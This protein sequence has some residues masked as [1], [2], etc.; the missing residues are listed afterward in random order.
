M[1]LVESSKS[2]TTESTKDIKQDIVNDSVVSLPVVEILKSAGV[3]ARQAATYACLSETIVQACIA[4]S[5]EPG[6]RNRVGYLISAL[7]KQLEAH[8]PASQILSFSEST[9]APPPSPLP[10]DLSPS[11]SPQAERGTEQ[12]SSLGD[13][14][15]QLEAE[16][17]AKV[18]EP[19]PVNERLLV[20]VDSKLTAQAAW[21]AAYHQL[22]LQLD[23][24][25][26]DTWL[27]SAVLLDYE[28]ETKTFVVGVY[29]SYARDMLQHRLYRNVARILRDV[30]GHEVTIRFEADESST[31]AG[32]GIERFLSANGGSKP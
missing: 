7:K 30:I 18:V 17:K 20:L 4:S 22:E 12:R 26:F 28:A 8:K 19:E 11:P 31:A 23:R 29:N 10:V 24:A 2:L 3:A 21:S 13:Y 14:M 25:S 15:R 16:A 6:V 27:R 32:K 1:D 9:T 5:Q